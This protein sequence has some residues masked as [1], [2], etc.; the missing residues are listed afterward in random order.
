MTEQP[1]PDEVLAAVRR[2]AAGMAAG[3]G[4]LRRRADLSADDV[5]QDIALQFHRLAVK[6]DN[7]KGWTAQA[8][9]HRLIDLARQKH[10][11][12][13]L[14][15]ALHDAVERAMGPSAGFIAGAQA[16]DALGVLTDTERSLFGEHL[17]ASSN[18]EL[19]QRYGY[20]SA[21]VVATLLHR[22]RGRILAAFPELKL[23]L[24]P[25]RLYGGARGRRRSP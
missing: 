12:A 1:S 9:R 5:A 23:D 22:I 15:E 3:D 21:A 2:Y 11:S 6:P 20:A 13:Y 8:T 25:Q 10:P 17:L 19:A 24:E 14:E 16:R 4:V 7:W 18:A